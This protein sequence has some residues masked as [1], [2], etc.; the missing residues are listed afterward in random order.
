MC[1]RS[2]DIARYA[3]EN[4]A[5]FN[6]RVG[7]PESFHALHQL[8]QTQA[9]RLAYWRVASDEINYRRLF[10][11]NDLAAQSMEN[12]QV[13]TATPR[14]VGDLKSSG[15]IRGLRNGH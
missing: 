8:I 10:D 6:G 12:A 13:F 1:R 14:L 15:N 5:L 11:V 3:E 4:V 2:A 9:Y 7:E